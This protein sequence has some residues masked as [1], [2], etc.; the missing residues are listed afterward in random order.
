MIT[1]N[2]GWFFVHPADISVPLNLK[3]RV[4]LNCLSDV[5]IHIVPYGP[6][7]GSFFFSLSVMES[8]NP[9]K[10]ILRK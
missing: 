7:V 10:Q 9:A 6:T 3:V 5:F 2:V 8:A 1:G 4:G